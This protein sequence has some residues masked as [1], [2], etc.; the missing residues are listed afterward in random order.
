[1]SLS[2]YAKP[3]EACN[4]K[5][6]CKACCFHCQ[7]CFLSKGLGI[8]Y[9]KNKSATQTQVAKTGSGNSQTTQ[10]KYTESKKTAAADFGD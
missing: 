6:W 5:C 8:R 9:K 3:L 4:D 2:L 1:M 7:L 10:K